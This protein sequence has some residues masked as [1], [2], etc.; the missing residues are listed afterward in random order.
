MKTSL[1]LIFLASMNS[2]ITFIFGPNDFLKLLQSVLAAIPLNQS[3]LQLR[4]VRTHVVI[5]TST[6]TAASP[7]TT[8]FFYVTQALE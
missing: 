5:Q 4:I 7:N 2:S 6:F 8:F 1:Q 3:S